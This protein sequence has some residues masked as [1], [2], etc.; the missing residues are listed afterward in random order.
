MAKISLHK[1]RQAGPGLLGALRDG[2]YSNQSLFLLL[3]IVTIS[4]FISVTNIQ[5]ISSRNILNILQQIS[6]VGIVSM[7]MAM[8]LIS[9]GI[10]LSVGAII[11]LTCSLVAKLIVMDV[12][13]W[14]AVLIG[15]AA[16]TLCGFIN[17]LIISKTGCA[18]FIITLGT[19]SIFQGTAL[20]VTSGRIVNLSG[21]FDFLGRAHFS[22]VP[23]YVLVFLVVCVIFYIILNYS[24]YGRRI[25]AMGGNEEATYL[26]G[27]KVDRYK[28]RVY[29][30]NGF[31]VGIASL[32]LLSRLGSGNPVMGNGYE[33]QSIAAAVIGGVT[34]DGG[35]GSVVGCFL[36]V[37]LLGIISNSLNI[38]GV[39]PFY[40]NMVLGAIIVFAVIMSNLGKGK[41]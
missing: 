30:L 26:S 38:L 27:I 40:Q 19:L 36:G 15:L 13:V 28:L 39:S 31:V 11:S 33:L 37:L 18:P 1:Q 29:S 25:Y 35:R 4:V 12:N 2:K 14:V 21:Q 34:L 5:F 8:V 17:G 16:A 10:D 32:V 3:V 24:R 23:T 41:R 9:G 6:V 20:V 7:G 22:F